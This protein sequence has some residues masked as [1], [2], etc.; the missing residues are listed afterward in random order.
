M[1]TT[2]LATPGCLGSNFTK[3]KTQ[4]MLPKPQNFNWKKGAFKCEE[5]M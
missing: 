4:E 1:S 2:D 5:C 3:Q